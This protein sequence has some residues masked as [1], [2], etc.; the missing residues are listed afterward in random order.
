MDAEHLL[1]EAHEVTNNIA[2]MALEA[3]AALGA[4][5]LAALADRGYNSH[6]IPAC[7][8]NGIIPLLLKPLISNSK[9]E[10]R[11]DRRDLIY[12]AGTGCLSLASR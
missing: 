10:G 4:D 12:G 2:P 8:Q 6:Q 1:I 11:F 7:E 5:H 9:T 3:K